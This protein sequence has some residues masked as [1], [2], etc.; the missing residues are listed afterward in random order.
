M[1][2]HCSRIATATLAKQ[3]VV[4]T[5]LNWEEQPPDFLRIELV[6]P[7]CLDKFR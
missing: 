7:M 5:I 1:R 2:S 6:N 4:G 3:Q